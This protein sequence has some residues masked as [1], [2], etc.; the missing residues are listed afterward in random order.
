VLAVHYGLRQVELLGLKW[1][2]VD[3]LGGVLQVRH[4]ISET[5]SG[6]I[7]E[8]PKSG[9]GCVELTRSVSEA[10]RSHQVRQQEEIFAS[11]VGT[12]TNSKNLYW[13]SYKPILERAGLPEIIFHEPRH[14]C[15]TIRFM[16]RQHPKRVQELLGHASIVQAMDTY[17]HVI[18]GM[19]DDEDIMGDI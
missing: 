5:R 9:K 1:S 18:P 6:R 8:Q 13:R 7:E 11:T 3:L 12:P 2:D 4:T 15:A 10:L 14:T 17:S 19:G 16:R